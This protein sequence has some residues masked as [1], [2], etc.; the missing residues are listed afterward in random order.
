MTKS[1]ILRALVIYFISSFFRKPQT[2]QPTPAVPTSPD[3]KQLAAFNYFENG[4]LFDLHVYLSERSTGVD[5]KDSESLIWFEEALTFGDWYSGPNGDAIFTKSLK[6]KPSQQLQSNGSIF[7]YAYVTKTGK[8]PNPNAGEEY[9]GK[10]FGLASKM[11]NKFKRIKY[12]KTVNLLT[13]STERSEE[14]QRKAESM[15]SEVM[16]HWHPNMTINLIFDSTPWTRGRVPPPLDEFVQFMP[17]E[18]TFEI[19]IFPTN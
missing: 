12:Q 5:W 16:S 14:E 2:S 10:A 3:G 9:A 8:S 17:G 11:L 15:K 13:G 6:F 1:L 19:R 18:L 7:L 4:T